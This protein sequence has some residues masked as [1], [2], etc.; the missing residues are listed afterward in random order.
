MHFQEPT[1]KHRWR[2]SNCKVALVSAC[3]VALCQSAFAAPESDLAG[4]DSY[5]KILFKP[6]A[7]PEQA[8]AEFASIGVQLPAEILRSDRTIL[9]TP[10]RDSTIKYVRDL[11]LNANVADVDYSNSDDHLREIKERAPT[12]D[13]TQRLEEDTS[14]LVVKFK[15]AMTIPEVRKLLGQSFPELKDKGINN[16]NKHWFPVLDVT[17]N[18]YGTFHDQLDV[19]NNPWYSAVRYAFSEFN[20]DSDNKRLD[21]ISNFKSVDTV[22]TATTV[23]FREGSAQANYL[24]ALVKSIKR[25]WMPS[26][27][28]RHGA[29]RT[30]IEM[31]VSRDGKLIAQEFAE[32]PEPNA[33]DGQCC[34]NAISQASP[35]PPLPGGARDP[36][37]IRVVFCGYPKNHQDSVVAAFVEK[38]T[39]SGPS[40]SAQ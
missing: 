29:G 5:T 12:K 33:A 4:Y 30:A 21:K 8:R 9:V 13:F 10:N 22:S 34:K 31:E 15:K 18:T 36:Q 20:A 1:S 19:L 6:D 39:S 38:S 16:I 14:Y 17:V 2:T 3:L 11:R 23:R 32:S 25:H 7:D 26:N 37:K 28:F 27:P 24:L 35:F 40:Q